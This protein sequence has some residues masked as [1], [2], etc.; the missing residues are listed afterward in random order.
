[1]QELKDLKV[2]A[3]ENSSSS[4]SAAANESHRKGLYDHIP[5]DIGA[6]DRAY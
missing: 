2:D 5:P 4:S 3:L 1:M 6:T